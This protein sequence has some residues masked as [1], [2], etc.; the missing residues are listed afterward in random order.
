MRRMPRRALVI[1]CGVVALVSGAAVLVASGVVPL[2]GSL[3]YENTE[4]VWGSCLP[5]RTDSLIGVPLD[6]PTGDSIELE[7]VRAGDAD[8]VRLV[9]AFVTT[10]DPLLRAG[11]QD[12][13]PDDA[14]TNPHWK[15]R[16]PAEG[17]VIDAGDERDLLLHVAR[18]PRVEGFVA[19]FELRYRQGWR[20]FTVPVHTRVTFDNECDDNA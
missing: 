3:H 16:V 8:G 20:M 6:F 2:S 5:E 18:K 12:F 7:S 4:E 11:S 15:A 1:G 14:S 10:V 19:D 9:E 17:A 13:P